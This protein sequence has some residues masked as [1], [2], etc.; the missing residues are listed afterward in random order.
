MGNL[1]PGDGKKARGAAGSK[2]AEETHPE[3]KTT[4]GGGK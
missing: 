4:A 1:S 2:P 3:R